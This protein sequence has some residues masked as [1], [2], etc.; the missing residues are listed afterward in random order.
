MQD[1]AQ[2]IKLAFLF[3]AICVAVVFCGFSASKYTGDLFWLRLSFVALLVFVAGTW[4]AFFCIKELKV[5][6][7][8]HEQWGFRNSHREEPASDAP[9]DRG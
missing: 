8:I 5:E 4:F 7:A 3:G 1:F 6:R 2:A 9:G